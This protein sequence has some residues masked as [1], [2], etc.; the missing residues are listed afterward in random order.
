M[1]VSAEVI[2]PL[3]VDREQVTRSKRVAANSPH[4][5]HERVDSE[6]LWIQPSMDHAK[7]FESTSRSGGS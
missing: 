3:E 5:S 6:I 4:L 2:T 1:V 7:L